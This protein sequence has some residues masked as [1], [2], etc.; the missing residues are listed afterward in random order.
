MDDM[1][2]QI[3]LMYEV[4]QLSSSYAVIVII[5]HAFVVFC[6][7]EN[8]IACIVLFEQGSSLLS[9]LFRQVIGMYKARSLNR[10]DLEVGDSEHVVLLDDCCLLSSSLCKCSE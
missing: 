4:S 2:V 8:M 7:R 1:V 6:G 10:V 9:A 3:Y 5:A